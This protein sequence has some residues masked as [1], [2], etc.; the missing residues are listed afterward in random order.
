M[1]YAI[2]NLS[3]KQRRL[4]EGKTYTADRFGQPIN[5][6]LLY[7]NDGDVLVGTPFV[8]GVGISLIEAENI[9]DKKVEIIRFEAKSG[10]RSH[11]GHRQPITRFKVGKIGEG[12][13]STLVF[14]EA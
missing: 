8:S 2:V 14:K 10:V 5:E 3:G 13:N 11:K 4:M 6:V 7:V 1:K 9:K 12:V